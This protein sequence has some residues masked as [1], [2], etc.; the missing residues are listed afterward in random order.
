MRTPQMKLGNKA[1]L[2]LASMIL[3]FVLT[4]IPA[5]AFELAMATGDQVTKA[6]IAQHAA[7]NQNANKSQAVI[8]TL[9]ARDLKDIFTIPQP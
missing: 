5:A 6:K 4:A 3:I 8:Q 9:R 7:D 2:V 1:R